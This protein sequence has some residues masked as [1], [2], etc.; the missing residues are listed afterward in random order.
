MAGALATAGIAVVILP[1]PYQ[2]GRTAPGESSGQRTLSANLAQTRNAMVQGLTEV[3]AL[4][5]HLRK[6]FDVP[7]GACGVSLGGHVAAVA[8]GAFPARFD[9]AAFLLAGGHV[10]EVFLKPNSVTG[11]IRASLA[12]RGVGALE[13]EEL[14]ADF[15]PLRVATPER[16]E[17]VLLVAGDRDDVVS[18]ARVRALA[19]AYGDA[20]VVWLD[21]GHYAP[22]RPDQAARMI[23][24]VREHFTNA[25]EER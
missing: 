17:N 8:Y 20:K 25:F 14:I 19:Q 9:A 13:A 10:S 3:A 24:A 6:R 15:E 16:G 12:R 2:H 4:A 23:S 11:R 21:G 7:V 18:P 22:V 1:L 5:Q